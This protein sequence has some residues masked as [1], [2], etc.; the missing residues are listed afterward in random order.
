MRHAHPLPRVVLTATASLSPS[1]RRS[2]ANARSDV[3]EKKLLRR[4]RDGGRMRAHQA[5]AAPGAPERPSA[6]RAVSAA[7][8]RCRAARATLSTEKRPLARRMNMKK[9]TCALVLL[10]LLVFAF[11]VLSPARA[12]GDD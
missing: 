1:R 9:E 12:A 3:H 2:L 10:V 5:A 8:P 6:S 7:P 11:P 4:T